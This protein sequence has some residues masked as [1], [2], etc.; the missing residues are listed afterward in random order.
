[1]DENG[2]AIL[3]ADGACGSDPYLG[4]L[5]QKVLEE[6]GK[7]EVVLVSKVQEIVGKEAD[8]PWPHLLAMDH[9]LAVAVSH[10]P[11]HGPPIKRGRK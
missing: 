11:L 5:G 10:A 4:I 8:P 7:V 6:L 2:L 1:M 9:M 3:I